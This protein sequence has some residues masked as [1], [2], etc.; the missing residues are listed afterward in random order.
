MP[1]FLDKSNFK[2]NT[3]FFVPVIHEQ[4]Q[5]YK[6]IYFSE[7]NKKRVNYK[8]INKG[9]FELEQYKYDYRT[10]ES[11]NQQFN[12]ERSSYWAC[13]YFDYDP[14]FREH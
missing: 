13:P 9:K 11:Y 2:L 3:P 8:F 12:N 6:I 1:E 4:Q 5:L 10:R 14:P 7:A